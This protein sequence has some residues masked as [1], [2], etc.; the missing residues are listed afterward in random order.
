MV[1][2]WYQHP[3]HHNTASHLLPNSPGKS[4]RFKWKSIHSLFP[5]FGI[6]QRKFE[7]S[8]MLGMMGGGIRV[9][10]I[11][12]WCVISFVQSEDLSLARDG[13]GEARRLTEGMDIRRKL[14]PG[15]ILDCKLWTAT[16]QSRSH[17][18]YALNFDWKN[19]SHL[20]SVPERV[21]T[22][23]VS[24]LTRSFSFTYSTIFWSVLLCW[25]FVPKCSQEDICGSRVRKFVLQIWLT[26]AW[27]ISRNQFRNIIDANV[28]IFYRVKFPIC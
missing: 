4:L 9:C 24:T 10:F 19:M 7:I 5:N 12:Q 22:F 28:P 16:T 3:S 27:M 21:L 17:K 25:Q 11:V 14:E 15:H 1:P 20:H 6:K 18:Q 26:V 13:S 2:W 8:E 23:W